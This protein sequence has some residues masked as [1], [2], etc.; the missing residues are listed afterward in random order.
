MKWYNLNNVRPEAST[1]FRNNK[2]AYLEDKI[3]GLAKNNKNKKDRDQYR[4]I[5]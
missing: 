5:N 1:H 2:G 3:N 4:G